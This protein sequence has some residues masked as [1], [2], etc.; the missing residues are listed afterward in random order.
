MKFGL[1]TL[2]LKEGNFEMAEQKIPLDGVAT[3][4]VTFTDAWGRIVKA[5]AVSPTFANAGVSGLTF[6]GG[7]LMISPTVIGSDTISF[8]G[9]AETLSLSVIEPTAVNVVFGD[10][11]IAPKS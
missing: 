1:G 2:T 4:P 5:P 6:D 8:Q 9:F 11:T 3:I 10:A 7:N